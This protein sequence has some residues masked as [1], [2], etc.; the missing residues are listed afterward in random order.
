MKVCGRCPLGSGVGCQLAEGHEGKHKKTS[1]PRGPE[2]RP[3]VYEWTDEQMSALI[4][5]H[6]SRFD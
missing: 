3:F 5:K 1:Y 4:A 6:I 2:G